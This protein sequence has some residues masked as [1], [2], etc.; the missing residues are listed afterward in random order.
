MSLDIS[1]R[2]I[3]LQWVIERN[4]AWI[5]AADVKAGAIITVDIS[6]MGGLAAVHG[7]AKVMDAAILAC[8]FLSF[9]LSVLS[10]FLAKFVV[11][12][13]LTGPTQSLLFFGPISEMERT[14]YV[15]RISSSTD[16][17]L[18]QDWA[19]QAHINANIACAKHTWARR[20]LIVLFLSAI[21]WVISV[22]LILTTATNK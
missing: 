3:T 21:P 10:I 12:P 19:Q 13:R 4:L 8:V 22:F 7:Q 16:E 9:C 6:M 2:L 14:D 15:D 17:S 1:K 20:S 11:V 5:A 18:L